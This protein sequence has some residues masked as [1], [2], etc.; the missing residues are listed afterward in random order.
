MSNKTPEQYYIYG[1]GTAGKNALENLKASYDIKGFIDSDVKKHG[2]SLLGLTIS[3]PDIL[4]NKPHIKLFIASEYTEQ[5]QQHL[6]AEGFIEQAQI[7]PLAARMLAVTTFADDK[8]K[9]EIALDVLQCCVNFLRALKVSHY[10]DAGT[11][12]GIYRDQKLIPWDDDLDLAVNS[13]DVENIQKNLAK[14]VNDLH[15][16]TKQ[17]WQYQVHY[18]SQTFGNV[19]KD[20][21]RSFK[22]VCESNTKL[23]SIDFFVKYVGGGRSDHSLASR[24]INI[25]SSY[26]ESIIDF[27]CGDYAWPIPANADAYL[28]RHYG[29]WRTPKPDWS[30]TELKSAETF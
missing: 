23:P 9:A 16:L 20:A 22:V 1:A 29:D 5:I 6:L 25:P 26:T 8:E 24:G 2:E 27:S 28:T 19:P 30:I 7:Q 10:L 17:T 12:L 21:V 11:L 18:A 15:T 4:K 13:R 14:L 3:S